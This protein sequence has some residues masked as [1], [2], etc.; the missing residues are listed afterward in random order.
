MKWILTS[1]WQLLAAQLVKFPGNGYNVN[2]KVWYI[3]YKSK[4]QAHTLCCLCT[5]TVLPVHIQNLL[6]LEAIMHCY[7]DY[8]NT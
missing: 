3:Y 2:N 7:I 6:I 8:L 1:K 5:Y 4:A